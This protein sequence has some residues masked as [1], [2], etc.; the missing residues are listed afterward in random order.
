MSASNNRRSMRTIEAILKVAAF[1][2]AICSIALTCPRSAD[3]QT[4]VPPGSVGLG[5]QIGSPSGITLKWY[6]GPGRAFDLFGAWDLDDFFFLNLHMLFERPLTDSPLN[7][8]YGPGA[9]IGVHERRGDDDLVVGI[10]GNFGLNFFTER[11]EVF[12]QLT[13]RLNIVPDTEGRVGGGVGL[14]YYF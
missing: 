1:S 11:F 3:A 13:P 12:L 2:V 14:R 10:S 8:F 6:E 9:Y 7:L 4:N 5:G